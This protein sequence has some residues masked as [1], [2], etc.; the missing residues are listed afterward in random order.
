[1]GAGLGLDDLQGGA[2]GVGGGVGGAAQQGVGLAHLHQHGAEIVTLFESGPAVLLAHL[3]AA[4]FHHLGHHLIHGGIGGGI[5]DLSLGD[6][7]A[8]RGCGGLHL[9]HVA[10]QDHVH[11]I[12][13]HKTL[14]G[15]QNA[16]VGTLGEYNGAAVFLQILQK[17]GKHGLVLRFIMVSGRK[18][19]RSA[20]QRHHYTP[21]PARPQR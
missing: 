14:G 7:K 21:I 8:A 2:D 3:A 13:G 1:M 11:Q 15:L 17:S 6:I 20:I 16:L 12:L 5:N 10:H 19:A 4:E 9:V 18:P